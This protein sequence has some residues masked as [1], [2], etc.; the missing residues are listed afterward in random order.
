LN[1]EKRNGKRRNEGQM[2]QNEIE[3][4]LYTQDKFQ[5]TYHTF[6]VL[7]CNLNTY[8]QY[9]N[10]DL[11]GVA[12]RQGIKFKQVWKCGDKI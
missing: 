11:N 12:K 2:G 7:Q 8:E 4:D 3:R 9:S 10:I 6:L 5:K 1:E